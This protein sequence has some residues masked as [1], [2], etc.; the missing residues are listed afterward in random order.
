MKAMA[1]QPNQ[2]K[3][4]S[5]YVQ[6]IIRMNFIELTK[7]YEK[8]QALKRR[9]AVLK[10]TQKLRGQFFKLFKQFYLKK[11]GEAYSKTGTLA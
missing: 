7:R 3:K 11:H 1:D 2:K 5:R 6:E 8:Q 4:P 9:K 10:A